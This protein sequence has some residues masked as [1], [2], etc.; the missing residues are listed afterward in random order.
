MTVQPHMA[1]RRTQHGDL[2]HKAS[3]NMAPQEN[4]VQIYVSHK[5]SAIALRIK[6][7]CEGVLLP[8][9]ILTVRTYPRSTFH[10]DVLTITD[11]YIIDPVRHIPHCR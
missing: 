9:M 7:A 4:V 1:Q 11:Q 8:T 5:N 6:T 10:A 2:L 3:P